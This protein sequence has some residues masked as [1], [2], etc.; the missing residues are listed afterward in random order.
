MNTDAMSALTANDHEQ[1]FREIAFLVDSFCRT[2]DSTMGGAVSPIG[3]IAGRDM[4]RKLPID[5]AAVD[6][7][8][9]M[10]HL[11]TRL[12]GGFDVTVSKSDDAGHEVAFGRCAIRNV[13][14]A[15]E[16]P[17]GGPICR[18]FHCYLDGVVNELT[19]RPVKSEITAAGE[20]CTVCTRVR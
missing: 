9:A 1:A 13:C 11:G 5:Q 12:K 19:Q 20:C 3:R 14:V 17:P 6:F 15:R 4:A 8:P 18:L 7:R 16:L 2:I 10:E